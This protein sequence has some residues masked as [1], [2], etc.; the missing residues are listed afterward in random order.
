M[1][2]NYHIRTEYSRVGIIQ[3]LSGIGMHSLLTLSV[4]LDII[5]MIE[6]H[7]NNPS[8]SQS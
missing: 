4:N 7:V 1:L 5:E 6:S 3:Y 8:T 2:L